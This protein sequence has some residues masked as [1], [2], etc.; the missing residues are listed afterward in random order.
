MAARCPP[1]DDF[2]IKTQRNVQESKSQS[3]K[4]KA[5]LNGATLIF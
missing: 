5:K 4:T 2:T 3:V 1:L